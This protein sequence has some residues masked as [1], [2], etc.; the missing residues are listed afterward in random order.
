MVNLTKLNKVKALAVLMAVAFSS[1]CM[2]LANEEGRLPDAMR[3]VISGFTAKGYPDLTKLPEAPTD[4]PTS[5]NWS[6]LESRLVAQ[7]RALATNPAAI[8]P[9]PEE[10]NLAWARTEREALEADPLAQPLQPDPP[11]APSS[12][13]WAADARAK[14]DADLARLPPP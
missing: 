6:A 11:G 13:Q 3:S 4:L 7:G 9:T 5:A 12:A 2:S 1:G 10:T 14:L 8:A